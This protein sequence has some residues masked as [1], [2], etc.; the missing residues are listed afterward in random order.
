MGFKDP[1]TYFMMDFEE[2]NRME[3]E[4][5]LFL[6]KRNTQL[7]ALTEEQYILK[8]E[9]MHENMQKTMYGIDRCL[10][11]ILKFQEKVIEMNDSHQEARKLTKVATP[12][13][14]NHKQF[15]FNVGT[16]FCDLIREL[17]RKL[18]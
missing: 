3:E 4:A 18:K 9:D 17:E 11:D 15:A 13:L 8:L 16:H 12:N 6:M 7:H 10:T 5:R 1:Y 14:F 2:I